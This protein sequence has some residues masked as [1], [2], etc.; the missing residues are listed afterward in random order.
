MLQA[1]GRTQN[2]GKTPVEEWKPHDYFLQ[3]H[4]ATG[5]VA[6]SFFYKNF[7][8]SLLQRRK[9][10]PHRSL[11]S[12]W[13]SCPWDRSYPQLEISNEKSTTI[14][15]VFPYQ[16][17]CVLNNKGNFVQNMIQAQPEI[18][19]IKLKPRAF[20]YSQPLNCWKIPI[21][22]FSHTDYAT[23]LQITIF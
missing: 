6:S 4:D 1:C 2:Q 20:L 11:S 19:T 10:F 17:I 22:L 7:I 14:L 3:P 12:C 15:V 13:I 5:S 18:K 21:H 16:S 23:L 9:P 8:N